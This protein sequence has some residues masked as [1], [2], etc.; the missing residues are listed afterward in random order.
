MLVLDNLFLNVNVAR[1]LLVLNIA[2]Y[3]IIRKNAA[4][5]P[6]DLVKIKNYNRLYLWDFCIAHIV[7]NIVIGHT[8]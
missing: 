8:M 2:S 7:E 4:G 5:F 6:S 3:G 1:A